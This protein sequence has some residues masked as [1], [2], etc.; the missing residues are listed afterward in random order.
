MA[1]SHLHQPTNPNTLYGKALVYREQGDIGKAAEN[2]QRASEMDPANP[3]Y[4]NLLAQLKS[5]R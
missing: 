4:K 2:M 5:G 3:V 1:G